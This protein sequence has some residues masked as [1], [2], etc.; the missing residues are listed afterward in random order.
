M[1]MT[2]VCAIL[3]TCLFHVSAGPLSGVIVL[4]AIGHCI[5]KGY[6]WLVRRATRPAS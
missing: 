6:G 3:A 2:R 1:W 4:L 5:G